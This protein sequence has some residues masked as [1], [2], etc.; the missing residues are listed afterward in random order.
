MFNHI[1]IFMRTFYS[2]K[3]CSGCFSIT[4]KRKNHMENIL[5]KGGQKGKIR[6]DC[7]KEKVQIQGSGCSKSFTLQKNFIIIAITSL[8]IIYF[9]ESGESYGHMIQR[10]RC[11]YGTRKVTS[12]EV[13]VYFCHPL[14]H[15]RGRL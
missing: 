1:L 10:R 3:H 15:S 4:K 12:H 11:F 6:S 5:H 9:Y 2:L 8:N 7:R 14:H 13:F